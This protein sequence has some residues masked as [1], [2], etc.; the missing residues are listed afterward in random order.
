MAWVKQ[1][2]NSDKWRRSLILGMAIAQSAN[3]SLPVVRAQGKN[4]FKFPAS[5]QRLDPKSTIGGGR[6]LL[7]GLPGTES[8]PGILPSPARACV[9][10]DSKP[11]TPLL[12]D[13]VGYEGGTTTLSNPTLYFYIP[14]TTATQAEFAIVD[15]NRR[16]L[17]RAIYSLPSTG[18]IVQLTLPEQ[19]ALSAGQQYR[20]E[21]ALICNPQRRK[22]DK[23][24]Q[25]GLQR[26]PLSPELKEKLDRA[27]DLLAKAQL[28]AQARIWQ[29][30]LALLAQ[31]HSSDPQAWQEALNSVGLGNV[32]KEPL[33]NCC[34]ASPKSN[35]R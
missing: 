20:W 29:E 18:G 17:Y 12:P 10:S 8:T 2:N 13:A 32:S 14:A 16:K 34:Q 22:E 9:P 21:F 11:L 3:F 1:T 33:L 19:V 7:E 30:T 31:V 25:G 26:L 23:F 24:V 27:P 35:V 15:A 4:P 6:R 28:Y 5:P